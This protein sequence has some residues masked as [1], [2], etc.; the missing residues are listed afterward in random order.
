MLLVDSSVWIAFFNGVATPQASYL[1]S[2]LSR[3]E[4][5]VGDL[6]MG[7]VLQGFRRDADFD[8]ARLAF[9]RFL[10]VP[11]LTPKLA[12]QSARNYRALRKRGVTMRKTIDC[13]IA[14]YAIEYGH[15]LLHSDADFEPFETYLQ[16][17]VVHPVSS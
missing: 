2:N 13:F 17:R 15:D 1:R 10:Q 4:I 7:E 12:V 14:T 11:I 9:E 8:R 6:I 16:L 3:R 5:V